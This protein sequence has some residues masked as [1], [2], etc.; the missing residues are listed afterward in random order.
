[1]SSPLAYLQNYFATTD[2]Q[3]ENVYNEET[4]MLEKFVSEAER[5]LII[6]R[7]RGDL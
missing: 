4:G 5:N 3:G 6:E 1:M 7:N 2:G